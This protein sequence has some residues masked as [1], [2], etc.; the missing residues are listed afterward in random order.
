[1]TY[2]A[3]I[4]EALEIVDAWELP[5]EAIAQAVNDQ[6]KIM[7]GTD[8]DSGYGLLQEYLDCPQYA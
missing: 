7:A 6:A 5:P 3:Y 2:E 8:L 4:A 1:M